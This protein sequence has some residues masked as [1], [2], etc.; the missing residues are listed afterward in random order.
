[1]QYN[2]DIVD[3]N[4]TVS[5]LF[6]ICL[7]YWNYL[8]LNVNAVNANKGIYTFTMAIQ[9]AKNRGV[10]A[11][12]FLIMVSFSNDIAANTSQITV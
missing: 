8:S 5:I 6:S 12:N 3:T 11:C 9:L 1:M 2:V 10:F 7:H 4:R